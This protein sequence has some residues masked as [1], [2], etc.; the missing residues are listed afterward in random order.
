MSLQTTMARAE[1]RAR[2]TAWKTHRAGCPAC[3]RAA[4]ARDWAGLCS[5]GLIAHDELRAARGE[6]ARERE[7]DAQP[8]TGQGV[9]L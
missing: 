2:E 5:D 9:L 8:I 6:L 1:V 3:I 7:A 4:R